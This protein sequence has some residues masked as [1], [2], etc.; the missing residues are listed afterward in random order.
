MADIR[1]TYIPGIWAQNAQTTIPEPPVSGQSYRQATPS[2]DDWRFGQAYDR[3]ADSA[4]YNELWYIITTLLQLLEQNGVLPYSQNTNYNTGALCIGTDNVIYQA[5][6]PSGPANGGAQATNNTAYW[7][8]PLVQVTY[9]GSTSI[10]VP[11]NGGAISLKIDPNGGLG[12]GANGVFVNPDTFST[13]IINELLKQLRLPQWLTAN[14]SFYVSPSGNNNNDGLTAETA[15]KT[16]AYTINYVAANYNMSNFTA[17]IQL[18]S[19]IYTEKISLTKYNST[20]GAIILNGESFNTTMLVG[21]IVGLASSGTWTVQ[22]IKLQSDGAPGPGSSVTSVTLEPLDGCSVSLRNVY[23]DNNIAPNADLGATSSQPIYN[24]GG[25]VNILDGCE[26]NMPAIAA[27]LT[28]WR[29]QGGQITLRRATVMNGVVSI[30]TINQTDGSK[31]T[32]VNTPNQPASVITGA[33]TGKRYQGTQGSTF[34]TGGGGPNY[35]PGT[36]DGTASGEL[37]S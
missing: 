11:T 29:N 19:G 36:I 5:L 14:T 37:Y 17:T 25:N 28:F 9:S 23:F 33:V 30:A 1:N 34:N 8:K 27:G 15:W 20:T 13:E 32:K 26:F 16:I 6:Q 4:R 24:V 3:L 2:P 21:S 7:K 31:F 18:A 10:T 12:V 22:N 35:F